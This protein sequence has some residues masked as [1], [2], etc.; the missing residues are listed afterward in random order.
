[1][2]DRGKAE[3]QKYYAMATGQGEFENIRNSKYSLTSTGEQP[4]VQVVIN[5][6]FTGEYT[7]EAARNMG[8]MIVEECGLAGVALR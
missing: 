4:P 3:Y 6:S 5:G 7:R 8:R 2:V 1:M